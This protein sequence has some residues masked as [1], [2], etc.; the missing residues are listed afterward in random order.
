MRPYFT[1]MANSCRC[2]R[3]V[4]M[5][6]LCDRNFVTV[7]LGEVRNLATRRELMGDLLIAQ[8]GRNNKTLHASTRR[9]D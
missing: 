5:C 4:P 2:Q 3:D 7:E 9:P 8:I 1:R 6:G